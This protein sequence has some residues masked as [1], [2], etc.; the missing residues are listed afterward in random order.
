[1][2]NSPFKWAGT[3][4]RVEAGFTGLWLS[5]PE[6]VLKD[7]VAARRGDA[8]DAT[9]DVVEKQLGYDLGQMSWPI[10][11]AGGDRKTTLENARGE[12]SPAPSIRQPNG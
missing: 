4:D 5:A 10:V 8:S 3:V 9:I 2:L 11:E 6:R 7:R 1:M 12:L